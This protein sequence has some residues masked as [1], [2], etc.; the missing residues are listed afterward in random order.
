MTNIVEHESNAK[1]TQSRRAGGEWLSYVWKKEDLPNLKQFY[2]NQTGVEIL[3]GDMEFIVK[4]EGNEEIIKPYP[5]AEYL[6]KVANTKQICT[7]VEVVDKIFTNTA[8]M[9]IVKVTAIL[10][11]GTSY[12]ELG[13]CDSTEPGRGGK[14]FSAILGMAQTRARNRAIRRA[15]GFSTSV[16]EMPPHLMKNK[17]DMASHIL[18]ICPMC[19]EKGYDRGQERCVKCGFV[20]ESL[21]HE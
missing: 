19:K 17:A 16:E 1:L 8:K 9:V 5:R 12:E 7:K 13:E 6:N 2:E 18:Q 3:P 20:K 14:P 15:L 10:P 4:K 21:Q 11:D